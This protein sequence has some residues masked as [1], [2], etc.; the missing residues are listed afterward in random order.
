LNNFAS[1]EHCCQHDYNCS[2]LLHV[3]NETRTDE[4]RVQVISCELSLVFYK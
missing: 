4:M 1:R 3:A 2:G